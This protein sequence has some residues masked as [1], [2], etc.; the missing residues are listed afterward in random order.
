MRACVYVWGVEILKFHKLK[1]VILTLCGPEKES[2]CNFKGTTLNILKLGNT[3]EK[4]E[5]TL[6]N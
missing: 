3:F 5:C 4:V 6:H 1:L 2:I